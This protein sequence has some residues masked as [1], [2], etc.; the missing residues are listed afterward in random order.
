M[1]SPRAD[2]ATALRAATVD[3]PELTVWEEEPDAAPAAPVL[4]IRPGIPYRAEMAIAGYACVERWTLEVV[5][6]VG[7]AST[8]KLAALDELVDVI[9]DVARAWRPAA[10]YQGVRIAPANLTINGTPL[11]V[12]IVELVIDR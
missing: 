1:S 2:L 4:M 10:T 3:R 8:G 11:H 7:A 9:R 6:G 5:A 12:A